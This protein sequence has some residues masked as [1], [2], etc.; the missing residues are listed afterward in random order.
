M[1][2]HSLIAHE[3]GPSTGRGSQRETI[4]CNRTISYSRDSK[5]G[6]KIL[7]I[8]EEFIV[9][10]L[11]IEV[12]SKPGFKCEIF[13]SAC[14]L[15]Y[16]YIILADQ[17]ESWTIEQNRVRKYD[18]R[19]RLYVGSQS[20]NNMYLGLKLSRLSFLKHLSKMKQMEPFM[21]DENYV[22]HYLIEEEGTLYKRMKGQL[23]TE[24]SKQGNQS[25]R[26]DK[27]VT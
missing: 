8:G 13:Y 3:V 18:T 1:I 22:G 11:P 19:I 27:Q 26:W 2:E 10:C 15:V 12:S 17:D 6:H 4:G 25:L 20:G 7:K 23:E 21:Q 16:D 14:H 24:V 5:S 9:V